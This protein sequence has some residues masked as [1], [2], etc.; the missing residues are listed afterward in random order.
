MPEG[1]VWSTQA[2][3]AMSRMTPRKHYP[4][5]QTFEDGESAYNPHDAARWHP[6]M[7]YIPGIQGVGISRTRFWGGH[8]QGVDA[9]IFRLGHPN[10]FYDDLRIIAKQR[11]AKWNPILNTWDIPVKSQSVRA[12]LQEIIILLE[13]AYFELIW[14]VPIELCW[15]FRHVNGKEWQWVQQR[16]KRINRCWGSDDIEDCPELVYPHLSQ[17]EIEDKAIEYLFTKLGHRFIPSTEK[18]INRVCVNYLRHQHS[19]YDAML[20]TI[21]GDR[22]SE[23]HIA[24][25][26][27]INRAVA[28]AY[29]WLADATK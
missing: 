10:P 24:L 13:I 27:E 15:D 9:V 7:I 25:K 20:K 17:R 1:I 6:G 5:R 19:A 18:G 12:I 21:P 26:R 16:V 4:P 23:G 2:D 14:D 29:P 28:Q 3:W 8:N 22:Y 11:N